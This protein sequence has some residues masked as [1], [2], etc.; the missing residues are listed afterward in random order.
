MYDLDSLRTSTR[1]LR[2]LRDFLPTAPSYLHH[3]WFLCGTPSCALGWSTTLFPKSVLS[4]T[5][6]G[7][8]PTWRAEGTDCESHGLDAAAIVFRLT[9][10]VASYIFDNCVIDTKGREVLSRYRDNS[11]A[12]TLRRLDLILSFLQRRLA[13]LEAE[14]QRRMARIQARRLRRNNLKPQAVSA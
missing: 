10:P 7:D 6:E 11:L 9:E 4:A 2:K 5:L 12:T 1:R 3:R 13:A 14:E 8:W